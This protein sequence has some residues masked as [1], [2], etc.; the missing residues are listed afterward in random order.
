MVINNRKISRNHPPYIIAEMSANHNGSL[1][2]ALATVRAAKSSGAD[3]IKLQTYTA[4][5][6][7]MDCDL[8][9]FTINGGPWHQKRLFDLYKSAETPYEWHKPIFDLARSIGITVFSTPF[10]ETAVD[11]LE[12]LNTPAYKIASFEIVDLPLIRYVAQTKKPMILS[13][14]MATEIEILEAVTAARD[15]GCQDLILLHCISSYPAPIHQ[16]NL[17]RIQTLSNRFR[18]DVG[19]SDHTLGTTA[20]IAAVSLGACMIEKHFI[21]DKDEIGPDSSFSILPDEFAVLCQSAR[22]SWDALGTGI[23]QRQPSEDSSITFRRSLY[24]TQD[25]PAGHRIESTDIRRIRPGFGLPPK[26]SQQ[27]VG[28]RLKVAVSK[29]MATQSKFFVDE[30]IE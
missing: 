28:N 18:V 14:G 22:D 30:I 17:R 3:A 27:I 23:F 10:D 2:R 13:T 4:E 19:L 16:G 24:F 21:L 7:T 5:T 29:G 8:P 12:N 15:S 20:A 26:Y 9:D 1:S 25:L 6:I 11:L